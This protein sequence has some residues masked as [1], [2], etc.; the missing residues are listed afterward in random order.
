MKNGI[1]N[2]DL[3]LL[4]QKCLDCGTCAEMCELLAEM[5]ESPGE[6][7]RRRGIDVDLAYSCF[8]CDRCAAACPLELRP[9][10]LFAA[11]RT[12]AVENEEIDPEEYCYLL[13]NRKENVMQLYRS[14]C[15]IDYGDLEAE[16]G[17]AT[18]F[19]PG[20]TLMT[21]SPV[22]TREV[23]K[24]LEDECGCRG[25]LTDCCGK[26]LSQMGLEQ[27]AAEASRN[28]IEKLKYLGVKRIV[29]A[30]PGCYYYLREILGQEEI[31]ILTVYEVLDFTEITAENAP[32]CTV[33]DSCPDRFKGVFSKGVRAAL[34]KSGFSVVEMT[35]N[36]GDT[37]CCGS[38]GQVSHFRPE[39]A[40]KLIEVRLREAEK[41]GA[42]V[43]LAY[44]LSC[45]LNFATRPSGVKVRHV[46]NLLLGLDEDYSD[47][48]TKVLKILENAG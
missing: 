36:R 28:L 6:L 27:R 46:L 48:K 26:P 44:C 8:L 47:V 13:P 18:C 21:Y 20:C 30:C 42:R 7:A 10:A 34:K 12:V 19:F 22:L 37:P 43:L 31:E 5:A 23:F 39:L 33:H 15:G 25:M 11:R 14:Y 4:Q 16:R 45:V 40:E 35:A 1:K 41:S 17:A 3:F 38:G 24:R 2:A 29:V 32:L 9:S